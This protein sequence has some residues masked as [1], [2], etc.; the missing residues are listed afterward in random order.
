MLSK[1]WIKMPLKPG[2]KKDLKIKIT[3]LKGLEQLENKLKSQV[4][5]FGNLRVDKSVVG[6]L[7]KEFQALANKVQAQINATEQEITKLKATAP[8][9]D[10]ADKLVKTIAKECSQVLPYY[11]KTQEILFRGID[12]GPTAF[13]G[14]SWNN[15]RTKD[16]DKQLQAV[17]DM[18]LK[19]NGF[20]ALRSNSIFTT[21]D[22]EFAAGYGDLYYIFPK[23]GFKYHWNKEMRDLVLDNPSMI[24]QEGLILDLMDDA[25][26]WYE[27]KTGKNIDFDL[28]EIYGDP[29]GFINDLKRIKFPKAAKLTAE[30]LVDFKYIKKRIGPTQTNFA[31]GLES[32]N[33]MVISGEYYAI[34]AGS[35]LAEH[36]L[37]ALDLHSISD[38]FSDLYG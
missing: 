28:Y 13:V 36:V 31:Q 38:L 11:R 18:V 29:Q 1:E 8:K 7:I 3:K 35:E 23:N 21:S 22:A 15:R 10:A 34:D 17:Y 27:K 30:S 25:S 4:A 24:F 2:Q 33:E 16:S 5:A 9:S 20:K 6:S 26:E 12:S 14:R 37:S 19:K 32:G